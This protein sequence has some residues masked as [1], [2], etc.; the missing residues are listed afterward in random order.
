MDYI[1]K[2]GDEMVRIENLSLN[3]FKKSNGEEKKLMNQFIESFRNDII[4]TKKEGDNDGNFRDERT[5]DK[6][7]RYPV[8]K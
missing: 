5:K 4:V 1:Q 8:R 7:T 2:A 6:D 3:A